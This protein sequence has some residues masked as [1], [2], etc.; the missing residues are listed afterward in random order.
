MHREADIFSEHTRSHINLLYH[1]TSLLSFAFLSLETNSSCVES[2]VLTEERDQNQLLSDMDRSTSEPT[3]P[4]PMP[5]LMPM[6]SSET[7]EGCNEEAFTA[8]YEHYVEHF[9]VYPTLN[10]LSV[11]IPSA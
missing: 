6:T 3:L 5:L 2:L 7:P 11:T 4:A 8:L 10:R 1:L 9:W